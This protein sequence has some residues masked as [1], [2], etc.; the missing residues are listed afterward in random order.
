[1]RLNLKT[2]GELMGAKVTKPVTEGEDSA[3]LALG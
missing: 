2:L 1:M 3:G